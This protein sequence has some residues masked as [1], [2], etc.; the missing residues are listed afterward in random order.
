MNV[1]L[2]AHQQ[3]ELHQKYI[4]L[5]LD[6]IK[7]KQDQEP[8]TAYCLI[9]KIPLEEVFTLDQW[10]DLHSK[11]M[12]NYRQKNW[13]FCLQALEHLQGKWQGELDSFYNDIHQRVLFYSKNDPDDTW[14]GVI[15]KS[16]AA[17]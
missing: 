4:V 10:K 11:L 13:N 5:E 6:T 12:K 8:V 16:T 15:D 3:P 9:E 17:A 7:I 2:N 14:N 1:I